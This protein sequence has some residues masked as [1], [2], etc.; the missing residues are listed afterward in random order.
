[1]VAYRGMAVVPDSDHVARGELHGKRI[2]TL[3][4]VRGLD[5]F[6]HGVHFVDVVDRQSNV[7]LI[8]ISLT[9]NGEKENKY[10]V[11]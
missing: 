10:R 9:F 2:S 11:M 7:Y 6:H 3:S 5:G 8:H 4:I 1:M